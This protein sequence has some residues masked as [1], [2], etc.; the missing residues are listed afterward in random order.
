MNCPV[1]NP[2]VEEL[3]VKSYEK[4]RVR[5]SQFSVKEPAL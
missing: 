3:R 4:L 1:L 5:I 2:F